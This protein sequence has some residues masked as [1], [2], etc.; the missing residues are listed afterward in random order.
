MLISRLTHVREFQ[1]DAPDSLIRGCGSGKRLIVACPDE[2]ASSR[3]QTGMSVPPC[4]DWFS[5]KMG[6]S[7][8]LIATNLCSRS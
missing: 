2:I 6:N 1:T 8:D 7:S 5:H 4:R 3:A